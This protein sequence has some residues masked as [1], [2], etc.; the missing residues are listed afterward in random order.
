MCCPV[1]VHNHSRLFGRAIKYFRV[2]FKET[3]GSQK[4][5]ESQSHLCMPCFRRL[6]LERSHLA[7]GT[8]KADTLQLLISI[9]FHIQV[10]AWRHRPPTH[11]PAVIKRKPTDLFWCEKCIARLSFASSLE[12][13]GFGEVKP[14]RE[15]IIGFIWLCFWLCFQQNW[16]SSQLKSLHKPRGGFWLSDDSSHQVLSVQVN[17]M[18]LAV[19]VC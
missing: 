5:S 16:A 15:E 2:C 8:H 1:L 9:R 18:N 10:Q 17:K 11:T 6:C 7:Q 12:G 14:G 4:R 19:R 3:V 13:R